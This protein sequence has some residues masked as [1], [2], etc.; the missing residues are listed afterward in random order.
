ML[1]LSR[2]IAVTIATLAIAVS[3]IA[4]HPDDKPL[5]AA[6]QAIQREVMAAREDLK[7]AVN[8][9]DVAAVK[10]HYRRLHA[11]TR[12]GEGR[13]PRHARGLDPRR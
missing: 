12:L 5:S 7:K 3:P 6:A 8:A 10:A 4:A 13:R 9:K 1:R 2:S 11:H